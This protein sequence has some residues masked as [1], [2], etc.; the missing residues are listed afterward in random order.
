[1]R[2]DRREGQA[3]VE[4]ALLAP[5]L[6]LLFIAVFDFG[7]YAYAFIATENATRVGALTAAD[8][9]GAAGNSAGVCFQVVE[10]MKMLPNMVGVSCGCAGTTCTAGPVQLTVEGVEGAACAEGTE[11]ARCTRVTVR[12]QTLPLVPLPYLPSQLT[13]QRVATA[14]VK[15]D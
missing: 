15:A 2:S 8:S 13:V 11:T 7:F 3:M 9:W 12:Y 10:E 14:T 6:F 1:M 5:W 4:T